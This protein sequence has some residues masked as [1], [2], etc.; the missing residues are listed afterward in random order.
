MNLIWWLDLKN[1]LWFWKWIF[2]II[3]KLLPNIINKIYD[4]GLDIEIV[5]LEVNLWW[6]EH[7]IFKLGLSSSNLM[8]VD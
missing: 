6:V 7:E 4:H 1:E 3:N 8:N 2:D 5:I